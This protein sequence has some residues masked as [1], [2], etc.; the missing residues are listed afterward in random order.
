[1]DKIL[2]PS[3]GRSGFRIPGQGKCS[4]ITTAVDAGVKYLLY[5]QQRGRRVAK[6]I[7]LLDARSGGSGVGIAVLG[8]KK[9]IA[10][11]YSKLMRR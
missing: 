6:W 11:N 10:N 2:R 1:M 5:L 8:L 4:L 3:A 7:K 9:E